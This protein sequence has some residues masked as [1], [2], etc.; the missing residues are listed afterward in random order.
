MFF[1]LKQKIDD[2][3]INVIDIMSDT[4]QALFIYFFIISVFNLV[5]EANDSMTWQTHNIFR[6][7]Q[8]HSVRLRQP[9]KKVMDERR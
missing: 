4:L 1:V 5:S 9:P 6:A 8:D 3:H 2:C 7:F